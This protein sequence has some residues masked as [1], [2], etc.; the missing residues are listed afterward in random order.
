MLDDWRV[1]A[2]C[3]DSAKG[4]HNSQIVKTMVFS[5]FF[6][7]EFSGLHPTMVVSIFCTVWFSLCN[8]TWELK[9]QGMQWNVL[10]LPPCHC[11]AN[12]VND[13]VWGTTFKNQMLSFGGMDNSIFTLMKKRAELCLSKMG[14]CK[15]EVDWKYVSYTY[16]KITYCSTYQCTPYSKD[17]S[18]KIASNMQDKQYHNNNGAGPCLWPH[19]MKIW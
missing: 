9:K 8:A 3:I 16:K 2:S 14:A 10:M 6:W 15:V 4:W 17:V 13:F 18:C 5:E 1:K 12:I 19:L 7:I 11:I